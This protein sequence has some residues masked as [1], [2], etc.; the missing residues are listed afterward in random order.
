MKYFSPLLL[1][2][3]LTACA[4]FSGDGIRDARLAYAPTG[5]DATFAAFAPTFVIENP[6]AEYNRIGTPS[7]GK[8]GN[9]RTEIFVDSNIPSVYVEERAFQFGRKKFRNLIYRVHFSKIPFLLFPFELG[10]GKNMGVFVIVT[11]N[12]QHLP[13]LYTTVHTCG[14]YLAF[15]PTSYMDKASYPPWWHRD[16]QHIYGEILPTL[17]DLGTADT[18]DKNV[19]VYL[20]DR[21]HRVKDVRVKPRS[22]PE[23]YELRQAGLKPLDELEKLKL[24]EG[25]TTSFYVTEGSAKGF[26][27]GSYKIWER[28]LM[29]W[30]AFDWR[31][32]EDKKLGLDLDD[33]PVFYTSLK[34]W[35][36]EES[37]MRDF[38]GFLTY[39]GWNLDP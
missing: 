15:I 7:A 19:Y 21:S 36:R 14:C 30:W 18:N 39:W 8:A 35:H 37:D 3:L 33:P 4:P 6:S 25:G 1:F 31:V 23:Q 11:L 34:F 27:K 26:V 32:G 9:G 12:E 2:L 5:N 24:P 20:R 16:E 38:A 13:I 10:A 22:D 29:S 28:L 17:L